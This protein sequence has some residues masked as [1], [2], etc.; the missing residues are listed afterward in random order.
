MQHW[1]DW[2]QQCAW[3]REKEEGR[4]QGAG[5]VG[6]ARLGPV[7]SHAHPSRMRTGFLFIL[8]FKRVHS[9]FRQEGGGVRFISLSRSRWL[10]CAYG[11]GAQ[12]G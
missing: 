7:S 12:Q 3:H 4:K 10:L 6:P 5:Q 1:G 2:K 8:N 9:V 11:T